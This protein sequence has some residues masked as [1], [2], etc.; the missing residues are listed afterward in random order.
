MPL[1]FAVPSVIDATDAIWAQI[2]AAALILVGAAAVVLAYWIWSTHPRLRKLPA[3]AAAVCYFL[4]VV[5]MILG[6]AHPS[7]QGP[8]RVAGP[9]VAPSSSVTTTERP[10]S[11]VATT[12]AGP[13]CWSA[14]QGLIDC[15]EKHQFE[16]LLGAT[17]CDQ[18]AV[19]R[20]LGGSPSVDVVTAQPA[21]VPG[22]VCTVQTDED[23]MGSAHNV[24]QQGTAAGW[25]RC[26]DRR[27]QSAV[28]CSQLH[29][30]EYV[31]TGS[32]RRPTPDEC[33]AA[34]ATYLNQLPA[35][36]VDDL[37]VTVKDVPSGNPDPARCT[38]DARG[39]QLLD[40]SVRSLGVRPVPIHT[41]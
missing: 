9:S 36:L 21:T 24:L 6:N 28:N 25:R 8:G 3:T 12:A 13:R 15:R 30:R 27:T 23:V 40:D 14:S 5:V 7:G 16:E 18:A 19:V 32:T 22:G 26:F 10:K 1:A 37:V 35:N 29:S 34:A 33:V 17:N 39:N 31:A 20:F 11:P 4:S 41:T 2:T 38:I